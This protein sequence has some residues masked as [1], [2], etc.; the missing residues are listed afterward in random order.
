MNMDDR[1][2]AIMTV[3]SDDYAFA[4]ANMMLSVRD[5]S[6]RVFEACDF[7][8]YHQGLCEQ[9]RRALEHISDR[10]RFIEMTDDIP[11][12][13]SAFYD[14]SDRNAQFGLTKLHAFE[15][16]Q[17]Y[18]RIVWFE[19]DIFVSKP[20]DYLF[21]EADCDIAFWP[22]GVRG[23]EYYSHLLRDPQ[24]DPPVCQGGV[25]V[26]DSSLNR[27]GL[28]GEELRRSCEALSGVVRGG[29]ASI[30]EKL[31]SWLVYCHEMR[32][33]ELPVAYNATLYFLVKSNQVAAFVDSHVQHFAAG[34]YAKP[35]INDLIYRAFPRWG[36]NHYRFL[37]YG[38]TN[39]P[40]MDEQ[41]SFYSDH[42][43]LDALIRYVRQASDTQQRPQRRAAP[44]KGSRRARVTLR[45]RRRS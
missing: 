41:Q 36:Y 26:F 24:D 7:I 20:V 30:E 10:I 44:G 4:A 43:T 9:N 15:H 3:C 22:C 39:C 25:T 35:W 33:L 45:Y 8:L 29:E 28:T 37:R 5:N 34:P 42:Y 31:M 38:G 2:Y 19:T 18:R 13:C 6:P 27:F 11:Q 12:I 16:L 21:F 14:S 23:R 17:H 32:Y 1:Q 40:A